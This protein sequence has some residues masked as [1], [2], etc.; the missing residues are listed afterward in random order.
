MTMMKSVLAVGLV[1][2]ALGAGCKKKPQTRAELCKAAEATFNRGIE[3]SIKEQIE[4]SSPEVYRDGENKIANAKANFI[5]FCVSLS[6]DEM[7]CLSDGDDT[8]A[9]CT[10][11]TALIQSKLLGM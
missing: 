7:K 5:P 6:D 4:G 10:G 3:K 1:L 9:K 11:M 8:S 2:T